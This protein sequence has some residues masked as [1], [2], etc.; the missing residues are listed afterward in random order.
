MI[1]SEKYIALKVKISY[2]YDTRIKRKYRER[3]GENMER[4]M[5]STSYVT[6]LQHIGLPTEDMEKTVGFYK[7]L[8]FKIAY[9][10]VLEADNVRVVFMKLTNLMIEAYEVKEA[11]KVYGAIDHIAIDVSDIGAVYKEICE[12]GLNNLND[13]VNEL[14]FWENGV[15]FF[16]IEG[17]NKERV[18]FGQLL[19]CAEENT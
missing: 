12:M 16:T 9:E 1:P 11:A 2:N 6:G 4:E 17:P 10:T 19:P 14:P 15:K 18:E 3:I 5:L 13:K 7:R 8:G